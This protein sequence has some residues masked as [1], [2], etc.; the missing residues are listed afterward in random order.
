[1]VLS[2]YTVPYDQV[3]FLRS[4][5]IGIAVISLIIVFGVNNFVV[6]LTMEHVDGVGAHQ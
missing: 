6:Q 3:S 2:H 5:S 4:C 1:M